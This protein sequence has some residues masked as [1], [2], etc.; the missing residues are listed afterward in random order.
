MDDTLRFLLEKDKIIETINSL[1]VF[2]DNRD[3]KAVENCFADKVH[4]D[5]TSM[6]AEKVEVLEPKQ[7]A[8]MWDEGFNSLEAI[9][10]QAGNHKVEIRENKAIAFCYGIASHYKKTESGKNTRTFVG[11]YNFHLSKN[12]ERWKIDSFKF[13]LKYVDGNVDLR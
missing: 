12:N 2:T 7:I 3:W 9:H 6:G 5:M 4:F 13:N 10:H 8:Q 1:F 11:S